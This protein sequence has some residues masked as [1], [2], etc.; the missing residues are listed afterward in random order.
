[1]P[2]VLDPGNNFR[3]VDLGVWGTP[4]K[5]VRRLVVKFSHLSPPALPLNF[6]KIFREIIKQPEW[7][8]WPYCLY[9]CYFKCNDFTF[10]YLI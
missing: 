3:E 7:K 9:C 10:I 4:G 8:F 1:M 5:G 2:C 6:R